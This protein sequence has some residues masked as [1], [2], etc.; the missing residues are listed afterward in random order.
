MTAHWLDM[1]PILLLSA[2]GFLVLCM[3][4]LWK[5]RA[6]SLLYGLALAAASLAGFTTLLVEPQAPQFLGM[7]EVSHYG[8]F[9][10]FLIA[11]I[12]VITLLFTHR[13]GRDRNFPAEVS[14]GLILFAALGMTLVASSTHWLLY[15]LGF[16]TLSLSLYV[17]IAI[18]KGEPGANEAGVKYFIL[19]AVSG[20]FLAFGIAILYAV[21]GKM[22]VIET[23]SA[24]IG[25]SDMPGVLLGLG[26]ILVG[27]GFKISLVPFH[28]WTPDVYQGSPAPI[29]AFL[30]SGS[31]VALFASLLEFAR[32]TSDSLWASCV[33]V[34]W[35]LSLATMV[36]GN[37][38]A[39][40]QSSVKRLLA[41]SSIA[42]MGYLLMTLL[43]VKG[44]GAPAILFYLV[45]FA[46]MDLGAFGVLGALSE[47]DKDLDTLDDYRG[48]GT[49][50]PWRGALLALCLLSLAGLPPMAGF[51]GKFALFQ[52][53][54]QS[55]FVVLA[56][57]GILT[58]ILSIYFYLKV[59]VALFMDPREKAIH[60]PQIDPSALLA[61]VVVFVLILGLGIFPSFLFG[62]IARSMMP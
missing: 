5:E 34:F 21:T 61:G 30:S 2:G 53:T 40:M 57:F 54:L 60:A 4:A 47:K 12:T 31:K 49:T 7:L 39:L 38:T 51:I 42:Q 58:A 62:V 1:L 50:H 18:R 35:V 32:N 25:P 48:L 11:L 46:L 59:I 19:G 14:Y 29:T 27:I 26:L 36:I 16:E 52:A 17:L 55:G 41:Y 13:Y 33:P 20:A 24:R 10:T 37:V 43:A 15:F 9:L 44:N 56:V 23:L 28:L 8:R 22:N 3:G 6:S 45:V